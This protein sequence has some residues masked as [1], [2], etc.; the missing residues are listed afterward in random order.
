MLIGGRLGYRL[1]KWT[2]PGGSRGGCRENPYPEKSKLETLLGADIWKE[3]RG[4][5]VIDF[6]CGV[7]REAIE[8]AQHGARRVIGIDIRE[9]LLCEARAASVA[10]G[11]GT[12]CQFVSFCS[13][14]ADVI[15]SLDAF[16]HFADPAAMLREME[17][18]LKMDGCVLASFGPTWYHPLGG[19]LFSVFPWAHLVFSEKALLRWRADFKTDGATRF[20]E[21]EGGL[22]QMTIRTFERIVRESSFT[23][24]W[25]ETVPI[26][27]VRPLHNRLTREFFTAIVRCKLVKKNAVARGTCI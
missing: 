10:A 19:H 26:R 2:S 25:F 1:L 13:E 6:G 3:F 4:K 11:V 24:D 22:N 27:L 7:G 15:I 16:E 23:F 14:Q 8:I 9:N 17:N 20:H 12:V 21:V 18:L 5:T